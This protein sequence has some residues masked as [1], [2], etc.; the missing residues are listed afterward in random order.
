MLNKVPAPMQV[1]KSRQAGQ[2][3]KAVG[4]FGGTFDPIH[5][6]HLLTALAVKEIR[7]LDKIIFI[8][9]FISPHKTGIEHSAA[10]HRLQMVSLA[11]KNISFFEFSAL[12]IE[13]ENVSYTVD[14]LKTLKQNYHDLELIIGY[15]NL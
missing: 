5:V 12:E 4:V 9:A 1:E 7:D 6:G 11:I 10:R 2:I 15:D 13:K 3:G 8:P 14:T